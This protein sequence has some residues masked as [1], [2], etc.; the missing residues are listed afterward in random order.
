[1][2]IISSDKTVRNNKVQDTKGSNSQ[3]LATQAIKREQL[4][5]LMPTIRKT[6]E[7]NCDDILQLTTENKFLK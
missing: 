7:I 2:K 3:S 5:S 4:V 6:F 1:M